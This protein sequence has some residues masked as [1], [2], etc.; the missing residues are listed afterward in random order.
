MKILQR[1]RKGTGSSHKI[2]AKKKFKREEDSS[3]HRDIN[4]LNNTRV[5][6]LLRLNKH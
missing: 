1:Q 2:K 3:I 5:V 6:N 4:M